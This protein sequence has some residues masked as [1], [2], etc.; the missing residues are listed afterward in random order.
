LCP[1]EEVSEVGGC[2]ILKD[3]RM[4]Q[5][6]V[7]QSA[8]Y[9]RDIMTTPVHT[10]D[11][12]HS[13]LA[14]KRLFDHE[15]CH[16]VVILRRNRVFG[17]VSDRDILKAVSPFVGNRMME[18][19]QDVNTLKKRV[20]QIMSRNLVTIGPDETVAEAARK[21]LGERVSC[22][23]VVDDSG[24]LLGIVTIRDFLA[25]A[26]D[27]SGVNEGRPGEFEHD[28]GILIIIDGARCYS[29]PVAIARLIREAE[30]SYEEIHG[31]GS[32]RAKRLP[33]PQKETVAG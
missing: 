33:N 27:A 19:S 11:M 20:H 10:V 14:A 21:M 5:S 32:A 16:H 9:V 13:M 17:V 24:S 26:V 12:D 31:A 25:W 30:S 1:K 8:M 6:L 15:R 7:S 18:R 22:L 28:K 23:P 3:V 4:P 2:C 29:P